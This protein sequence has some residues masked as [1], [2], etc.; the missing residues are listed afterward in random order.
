MGD[1]IPATNPDRSSLGMFSDSYLCFH[2]NYGNDKV[3]N[4]LIL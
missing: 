2:G 1:L 3:G 4:I